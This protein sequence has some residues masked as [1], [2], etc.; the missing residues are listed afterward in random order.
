MQ[1]WNDR[2]AEERFCFSF[3]YGLRI[4]RG[5]GGGIGIQEKGDYE[6]K[7]VYVN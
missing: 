2:L 4:I 5:V 7:G 3:L 6:E 1:F